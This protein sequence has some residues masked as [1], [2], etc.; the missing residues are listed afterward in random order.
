[1]AFSGAEIIFVGGLFVAG[2]ILGTF[3]FVT[4]RTANKF[5]FKT[6][7]LKPIIFAGFIFAISEASLL[8]SSLTQV[9]V[10]LVVHFGL[11]T[12]A[13]VIII[14]AVFEYHRMLSESK[15]SK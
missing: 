12:L 7:M 4:R 5:G 8:V 11:E 2:L 13:L 3:S 6:Y 1:M 14:Y 10:P 15:L 9:E